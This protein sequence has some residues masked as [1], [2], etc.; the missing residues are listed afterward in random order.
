MNHHHLVRAQYSPGSGTPFYRCV[1]GG[2]SPVIHYGI[3]DTPET[4]MRE[5]TEAATRRLL[6]MAIDHLDIPPA[7]ILDLGSG[8]GGSAHLLAIET[9]ATVTCVDLCEHHNLENET[10]ARSLG[11]GDRIRTLTASFEELPGEWTGCFD[12]VWSQ[13]ALCHSRDKPA[14]LREARRVLR[15]GGVL[16][17]S[18]ILLAAN[19]PPDEVRT[20]GDVNAV[21]KW[22]TASEHLRDLAD[23]GFGGLIHEDWTPHLV[24]NFRRMRSQIAGNRTLLLD[25]GVAADLLDRFEISLGKRLAWQPGSVLEWAAFCGRVGGPGAGWR[26]PV[27]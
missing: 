8:P 21:A 11:L 13:E 27:P 10:I 14:V 5:A 4:S 1:M 20:F 2:G 3:Y 22:T 9:G 26:D 7:A 25:S 18:D 24:E 12:L 19:A 16:V 17:F 23:A 6:R 15:P